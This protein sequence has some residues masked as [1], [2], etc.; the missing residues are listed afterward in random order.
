MQ[1]GGGPLAMQWYLLLVRGTFLCRNAAKYVNS[2]MG[3]VFD[4]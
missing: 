4:R 2:F 3:S 1:V